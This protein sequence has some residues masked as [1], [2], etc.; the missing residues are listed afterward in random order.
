MLFVCCLVSRNEI[1]QKGMN[2]GDMGVET[3]ESRDFFASRKM[4][5]F[6]LVYKKKTFKIEKILEKGR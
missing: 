6:T 3:S 4:S 2:Y 1:N 5:S